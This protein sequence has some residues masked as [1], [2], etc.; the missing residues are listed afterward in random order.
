MFNVSDQQ[1]FTSEAEILMKDVE[2]E[3]PQL[4]F[5]KLSKLGGTSN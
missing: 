4:D 5:D 2:P 3:M 1:Y